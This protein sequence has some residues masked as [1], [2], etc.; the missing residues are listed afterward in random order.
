MSPLLPGGLLAGAVAGLLSGIFGIGGGI[1]LVPALGLLLALP[2]HQAQ[3]VTLAVLLLPVGLP[4]VV[5]YHRRAPIRPGLVLA[6][7]VTFGCGGVGGLFVPTATMGAALGAAFDAAL[8]PSQPG[9]YTLLGIAAFAG[10]SYNSLLFAAVFVA[11]ATGNVFLVVP[12]LIA[13]SVA[14][15]VAAGVSNSRAQR[16]RREA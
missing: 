2:Q 5:A 3:G 16:Q 10:A 14:F 12:S 11:E 7:S 6:T 9:V 13:S 1:V 15:T 8:A 4:A